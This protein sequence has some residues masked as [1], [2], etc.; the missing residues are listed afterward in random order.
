MLGAGKLAAEPCAV[1][2]GFHAFLHSA[3]R[4]AIGGTGLTNL[5]A[6]RGEAGMKL[7]FALQRVGGEG[8]EAGA[9]QHQPQMLRPGMLAVHF[10]AMG[11]RHGMTHSVAL[12]QRLDGGARLLAELV[13]A[14]L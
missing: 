5:G 7:A 9:I 11:Q 14:G 13:H 1:P 12:L 6:K 4:L 10:Q 8:T 2:A 3:H